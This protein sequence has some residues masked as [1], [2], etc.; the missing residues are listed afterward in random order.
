MTKKLYQFLSFVAVFTL[1][2]GSASNAFA[3]SAQNQ[4][5]A[6]QT[7]TVTKSYIVDKGNVGG[8]GCNDSWPGT[9]SQPLCTVNAGL[10]LAQ[11]GEGVFLRAGTYPSFIV[12]RSGT[13]SAY[14]TIS[15][16]N[17]EKA[18]ISGG[19][20][21]IQLKGVS[22][23]RISGL[24]VTGAAGSYGAGI[25][26]TQSSGKFPYYNIIENNIVHDNLG[27]NTNGILIQNGSYNKVV[28]NKVY[29]NYLNGI[30]VLSHASVSPSGITGN[31]VSGNESYNNILGGKNSDGIKLEGAG[32]TNTLISNNTV[33]GNADDGIDTWNSPNNIVIGN[34]A[35]GQTGSGDGNGFKLGGGSTG[36][37]NLVKQNIAYGN[38]SNGFDSNGTGGNRFY[39]NI[40]YN[41]TNFGF[42]DGW[43]DLPCTPATCQQT[44]INNIG[45]N[46]V[47]GNFSASA[48]TTVSNNNLWYS[49]GGS[50][51]VFYNYILH[52]TLS[53]F[54]SASGNR[55]DN[56]SGGEQAS[57][58][59]DPKFVNAAGGV[60]TVQSSSPAIDS[61]DPTNPGGL[62][63]INRGDIGVFESE[64]TTAPT[65]V[66][67]TQTPAASSTPTSAPVSPTAAP[68]EA[69]PTATPE[70]GIIFD[71]SHGAFV[72]SEGWLHEINPQAYNG[73]YKKSTTKLASVDFTFTGESFSIIYTSG[74][75]FQNVMVYVD[76]VKVDT[77]NQNSPQYQYQQRWNYPGQLS[78]GEHKLRLVIRNKTNTFGSLDMVIVR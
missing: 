57:V 15:S 67:A 13:S 65:Q 60:F 47:R 22:Y 21:A 5:T 42:E 10:T 4:N 26:V 74:P 11:P 75:E 58:Q 77:I 55:L 46:N 29:N 76:G 33:H 38:K 49:D 28:N 54:Y 32:T 6:A 23:V 39:N 1:A 53:S 70:P 20:D 72:Y 69:A 64:T 59:A 45:Y 24:E 63:V 3:A 19:S 2:F 8:K 36:G 51:K 52:T 12:T 27:T 48:Y 30:Q 16:Y 41:N 25:R 61:G 31:E 62:M 43:K 44:F 56:P 71:D 68:T 50:A 35:Y 9:L 14:I 18:I 7:W 73:Y 78:P 66:V 40:A 34:I 37:Y 17:G